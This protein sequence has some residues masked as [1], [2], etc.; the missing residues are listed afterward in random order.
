MLEFFFY[1][2]HICYVW[3][4]RFSTDSRHTVCS[5]SRRLVPL[6]IRGRLYT[7]FSNI[8][9]QLFRTVATVT[10]YDIGYVPLVISTSQSFPHSWFIIGFVT[11]VARRV[12][13]V[14]QGLLTL[15][16]HLTWGSCW[17]IFCVLF[18]RSLCFPLPFSFGHYFVCTSSIY[19]FLLPLWYLQTPV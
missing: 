18:C 6:F 9:Y 5:S 15:S 11:K 7:G 8:W 1:W 14:E 4:T 10:E 3:W 12:A 2:Q 13:L 16:E 17:S 19:G